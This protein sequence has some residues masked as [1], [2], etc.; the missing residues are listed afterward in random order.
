MKIEIL[1][2][3]GFSDL[4]NR[5]SQQ[6]ALFPS[7]QSLS[8]D[9]R[10]F[11]VCDGMGGHAKGEVASNTV[12]NSFST[13]SSELSEILSADMFED[14]LEQVWCDLDSCYDEG[15]GES[16]MGTTLA[17]LAFTPNG[18]LAAHIGDSRI[19]HIR[20]SKVSQIIYR[21]TDHSQVSSM[22]ANGEITPIDSLLYDGKNILN[23][24]MI[25][26][27]R[28]EPEIFEGTDVMAGDYFMLCSDGV[29][30]SLT[31]EMI[32]FIFAPYRTPEE[33]CKLIHLH[34]QQLS[35][36]NNTCVIVPVAGIDDDLL[37]TQLP[38]SPKGRDNVWQDDELLRESISLLNKKC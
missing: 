24:A 31:D 38:A 14:I 11:I 36:D 13:H 25:P 29:T 23:K 2:P 5:S 20:P 9:N 27:I 10:V 17:F 16:Q 33:I 6:D 22:L 12:V 4:G 15:L 37:T 28:Y 26:Q 32:R 7:L 8:S 21:S 18:Y 19:Y 34:C 30:E 3:L 35:V 1:K